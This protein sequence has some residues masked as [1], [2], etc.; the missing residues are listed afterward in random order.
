VPVDRRLANVIPV[1]RKGKKKD[2]ENNRP[3][4]L[5]SMPCKIRE[6]IL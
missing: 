6:I 5:I 4:T 2:P 1:F 3:V